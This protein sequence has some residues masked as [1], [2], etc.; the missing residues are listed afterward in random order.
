MIDLSTEYLGL[1]LGS[2]LVLSAS[3]LPR[4]I[5]GICRLKEAGAAGVVLYSPFEEQLGQEEIDLIH[6]G[7]SVRQVF[8]VNFPVRKN[9]EL[10]ERSPPLHRSRLSALRAAPH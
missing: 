8:L 1:K 5:D 7:Y 4:D 2:P 9:Q 6:R 10:T 3:P